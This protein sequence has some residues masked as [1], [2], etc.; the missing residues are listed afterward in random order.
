[1]PCRGSASD[2]ASRVFPLPLSPPSRPPLAPLS[3]PSRPP[4]VPEQSAGRGSTLRVHR[5]LQE[6]CALESMPIGHDAARPGPRGFSWRPDQ[7][8]TLIYAVALDGGDPKKRAEERDQLLLLP[9]PFDAPPAELLRT[10]DRFLDAE[11]GADGAALVW[12]RKYHS[13]T[14]TITFVSPDGHARPYMTYDYSD[15]Y[16]HPGHPLLEEGP[17]GR[18]VLRRHG[19]EGDLLWEGG[20]ASEDGARP[21]IDA[22]AYADGAKRKRLWRC[23]VGCY[24]SPQK[25]LNIAAAAQLA[26]D[27]ARAAELLLATRQQTQAQPP[28]LLLRA[29][30]ADSSAAATADAKTDTSLLLTALSD[31]PHPQPALHGIGK[32]LIKYE[33]KDGVALSGTLYTPAG[34]SSSRD[35]TLPTILWAYPREYKSKASASQVRGSEHTFT[36]VSWGSPLFWLTRGYAVLDGFAMPIVGEEEH[37]NDHYVEQL[38][39]N[40]E[41]AVAALRERGVSDHRVAVGGH[42]YG[43]FMTANWRALGSSA[44]ASRATARTTEPSRRLVSRRRSETSGRRAR[45][46]PPC[47]PTTTP[48]RSP[49]RS[50]SSSQADPNRARTYAERAPLS[51]HQ[52]AGRHGATLPAAERRPLL[53]RAG[54][55]L[56]CAGGAGRVAEQH[57]RNAKPP[58]SSGRS[59]KPRRHGRQFSPRPSFDTV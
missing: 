30:S 10:K 11:F 35:G 16:N 41:A 3:P 42:S 2:V 36:M 48:T 22:R 32:A 5:V 24:D 53:P 1:M 47:R 38:Q 56:A 31:P 27:E 58:P 29:V 40:A 20:G 9:A 50:F 52:G 51:G 33:R 7:P 12:S 23:A 55:H 14:T 54:E 13:R 26:P 25:V 59:A 43:A 19:P 49:R 17:Y 46:T 18:A 8:C 37:E 6:T 15:A 57:V 39:M 21:F 44:P 34:Y 28:Q 45:R 4:L